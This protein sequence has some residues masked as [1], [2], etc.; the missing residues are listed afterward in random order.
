MLSMDYCSATK[1]KA[2]LIRGWAQKHLPGTVLRGKTA[3]KFL[4]C[5]VASIEHSQDDKDREESYSPGVRHGNEVGG[6]L[7]GRGSWRKLS[8]ET[9]T[10]CNWVCGYRNL[11]RLFPCHCPG[12]YTIVT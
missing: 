3:P 8:M 12:F 9:E 7:C 6:S 5:A 4:A 11:H 2:V 1:R 10:P